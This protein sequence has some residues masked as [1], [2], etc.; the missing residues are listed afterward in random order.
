MREPSLYSRL[1]VANSR[2]KLAS[3]CRAARPN[4]R[5]NGHTISSDK[6]TPLHAGRHAFSAI[7]CRQR[8]PST[9]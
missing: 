9:V 2:S 4:P 5:F 8:K 1:N 7:D 3:S 6:A